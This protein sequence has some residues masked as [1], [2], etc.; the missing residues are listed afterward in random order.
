[1]IPCPKCK[2]N[3]SEVCDT[4]RNESDG[5]VYRR[6]RCK[7]CGADFYTIECEISDTPEFKKQWKKHHRNT[8]QYLKKV[9]N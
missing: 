3:A 9:R 6:R 7:G 4:V 1:M 2:C 8:A 5:E